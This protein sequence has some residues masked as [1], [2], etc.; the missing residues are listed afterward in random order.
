[1]EPES[2]RRYLM[3]LMMASTTLL[4]ASCGPPA[5]SASERESVG[6]AQQA[7]DSNDSM[8]VNFDIDGAL[9]TDTAEPAAV[10]TLIQAQLLY[11]VGVLNQDRSLGRYERL[12]LSAITATPIPGTGSFQVAYRA[13]LPVAWGVPTPPPATYALPLP[14]RAAHADQLAF[15]T[16]YG[17]TCVDP[18]A[19]VIGAADAGRMFLNY[20]PQ[21]VGCVLA[22][23]DV[24]TL[25]ATTSPSVE[26]TAGKYPEYQRMW[27]DGALDVVAVFSHSSYEGGDDFGMHAFQDFIAR[28]D[29]YLA[30]R[31]PDP[32][33]RSATAATPSV[34]A[35]TATL[36]DGR[37]VRIDVALV[38]ARLAQEGPAFDAWYGALTP[39]A[40]V[41][42]YSGHA[43]LGENV[44]TIMKKG[45]FVPGKY[46]MWVENACDTFAYVD[47]TLADRRAVVN[48]DD[49]SGT[50]YMDTVS[51]VLGGYF[52]TGPPTAVSILDAMVSSRDPAAV[53]K[54]YRQ[55]FAE[56]DPEQVTVVTGEEDNVFVPA[57][58]ATPAAGPAPVQAT[59]QA[60]AGDE[61]P[62]PPSGDGQAPAQSQSSGGCSAVKGQRG[63][64]GNVAFA[65]AIA[66]AI[67][68]RARTRARGHSNSIT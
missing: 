48:P 58:F 6:S 5:T 64:G 56:L 53:P 43:D 20:R 51:T 16:K 21:R 50:K 26:N 44:R 9:V 1:M 19:G 54:T 68:R 32:T 2:M 61:T 60:E 57:M 42:H 41:I 46:V 40:D 4:M 11:G 47:R 38:G 31:Q 24:V 27:E 22:P 28:V 8:L 52:G 29:A 49:P 3:S 36:P 65:F 18:S 39:K 67:A 7:F 45:V 63:G 34:A 25:T 30:V 37:I 62:P 33:K 14:V 17:G 12:E 66:A 35:R 55:L 23:A 59:D 10:R 15:A 13:K